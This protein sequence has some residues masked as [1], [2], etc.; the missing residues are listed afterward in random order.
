M[1]Y[2]AY[3]PRL[4]VEFSHNIAQLIQLTLKIKNEVAKTKDEF[5][6]PLRLAGRTSHVIARPVDARTS[7]LR[8]QIR[9]SR[10][11]VSFGVQPTWLDVAEIDDAE[12]VSLS[13][14]LLRN[15][16]AL[17]LLL[18]GGGICPLT[19]VTTLKNALV[20]YPVISIRQ[21]ADDA[22]ISEST[23][24]RWLRALETRGVLT[25]FIQ[26]GQ[27]QFINDDLV[28]IINKYV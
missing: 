17:F 8:R 9:K 23:A 6:L 24:K 28:A 3:P 21:L 5:G 13:A 1:S 10:I 19:K 16:E 14:D 15:L 27:R 4:S 12:R 22:L 18:Q 7:L 26:D 2:L 25:S 11:W 20:R